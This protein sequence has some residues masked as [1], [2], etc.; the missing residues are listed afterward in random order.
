MS[1]QELVALRPGVYHVSAPDGRGHLLA[2]PYT[3]SLGERSAAQDTLLHRLAHGPDSIANLLGRDHDAQGRELLDRLRCKGWLSA[4][5]THDDRP[6]YT[7]VPHREPPTPTTAV[8]SA[9]SVL[10]RFAIVRHDGEGMLV[11]SPLSWCQV[12]VHDPAVLGAFAAPGTDP[13]LG[14]ETGERM[15]ADLRWAAILVPEHSE[16]DELRVCQWKPHELWFH[17]RSR[18]GDHV[19]LGRHF[20]GTYWA[21]GRFDPLP[22]RPEPYP[23]PAIELYRPDLGALARTDPTLT[24]VL[25]DRRSIRPD[26]RRAPLTLA[27]LGEF[28]YRCARTRRTRE[29][30]GV[31]ITSRPYP[32]G[33]SVYELEL[34]PVLREVCGAE[35]GM[36]HY[37]SHG[38]RLHLV[39]RA[40]HA[41]VRRLLKSAGDSTGAGPPQALLVFGF[42]AGRLMW[43]YEGMPY[44]LVLKH[45]GV[46]QQT[47]YC[48]A[49]AMGLAPCALGA[50]DAAAF[51]EATERDPLVE[52]SVGEFLLGGS[53]LEEGRPC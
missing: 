33:G 18:I 32:S 21:K 5:V 15:R 30:G 46:L 14:V 44:A 45:V 38:H 39:R 47:M 42:R 20:G 22:A 1:T 8:S 7:I 27:Q 9:P 29:V 51:T 10:S 37:D 19:Q 12:R 49:T 40:S 52:C 16:D 31:Q 11:E 25:E 24:A 41:S 53:R 13:G 4:T 28:L 43:K 50:G 36:Y 48:V 6:L 2:W 35:P 23:G 3:L 26:Q 17:H 34:Y